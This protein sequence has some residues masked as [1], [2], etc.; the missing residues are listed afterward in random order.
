LAIILVCIYWRKGHRFSREPSNLS[1]SGNFS[2]ILAEEVEQGAGDRA[3]PISGAIASSANEF[4]DSPGVKA[5]TVGRLAYWQ[6]RRVT[7]TSRIFWSFS[8]IYYFSRVT[9]FSS[10]I[11]HPSSSYFT[12]TSWEATTASLPWDPSEYA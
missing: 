8:S 6:R 5:L 9:W 10:I 12:A 2:D 11:T 4:L 3:S 7:F 1:G